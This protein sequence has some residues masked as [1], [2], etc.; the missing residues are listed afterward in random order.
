MC[1]RREPHSSYRRDVV[2]RRKFFIPV[3]G[4]K[5]LGY[6]RH[7]KFFQERKST[8][9]HPSQTQ[10]MSPQESGELTSVGI[11]ELEGRAIAQAV[12]RWLSTAATLVRARDWSS[13]IC[14]GQSGAGAG[15]LRVLGFTHPIFIPP[16][17]PSL[18]SPVA[19]TIGQKWPTC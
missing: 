14:G 17:S 19:G 4:M 3:V 6:V 9:D 7:A 16:D 8:R 10:H 13:R 18:H 2:F 15:F 5:M 11:A 1:L 12:S